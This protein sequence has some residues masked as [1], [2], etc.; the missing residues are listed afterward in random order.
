MTKAT[1][2]KL[3]PETRDRILHLAEARRRTPHW[4]MVDAIEQYLARE[5]QREALRQDALAAWEQYRATGMH[6]TADEA[7]RWL[8]DLEAGRKTKAPECHS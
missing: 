1:S 4:V 8:A 6:L 2:L 3:S 7:D 5:E